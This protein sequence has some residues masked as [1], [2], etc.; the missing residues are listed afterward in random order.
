MYLYWNL[1]VRNMELEKSQI[2]K[3]KGC[4]TQAAKQLELP[5]NQN[6][7]F[8]CSFS[9]FFFL[10]SSFDCC[11]L[12]SSLADDMIA[13]VLA[14]AAFR[15][16]IPSASKTR[17]GEG[18]KERCGCEC[19]VRRFI[20]SSFAMGNFFEWVISGFWLHTADFPATAYSQFAAI[21]HRTDGYLLANGKRRSRG[22]MPLLLSG[23]FLVF[24]CVTFADFAWEIFY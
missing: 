16:S 10:D 13:I 17:R 2:P 6:G 21:F 18:R 20:N 19:G 14:Y 5:P 11:V 8:I 23:S 22:R 7:Y 24:F 12:L 4:V 1:L 3:S 15:V 9:H